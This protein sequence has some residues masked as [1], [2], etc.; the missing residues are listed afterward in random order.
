MGGD[1][2]KVPSYKKAY[3]MRWSKP[4]AAPRLGTPWKNVAFRMEAGE[5]SEAFAG[6]MYECFR[7]EGYRE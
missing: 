5:Q 2:C 4:C 7:M 6:K 3:P 1:K